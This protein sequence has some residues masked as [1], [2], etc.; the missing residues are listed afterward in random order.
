MKSNSSIAAFRYFVSS[1]ST[2]A[3]LFILLNAA[4]AQTNNKAVTKPEAILIA[5]WIEYPEALNQVKSLPV[6]VRGWART[7]NKIRLTT[8]TLQSKQIVAAES[9]M[10]EGFNRRFASLKPTPLEEQAFALVNEQRLLQHLEPLSWDLEML[11]LAREHSENMARLNFFSHI[12]RDGKLPDD[13]AND[14]GIE[15]CGGIG[16]NIAFNQ[17]VKNNIEVA[18]QGWTNSQHHKENLLDKKWTRSGIGIAQ[19]SDGKFYMTQT[20]RD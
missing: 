13:R 7:T 17:G 10:A 12:G 4:V 14:I 8:D 5:E 6:L 9:V 3:I 15:D 18:I 1:V 20:F 16:E 2:I 11:Y 19:T